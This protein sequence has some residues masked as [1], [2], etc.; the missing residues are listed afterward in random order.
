MAKW[1][2][3]RSLIGGIHNQARARGTEPDPELVATLRQR[4]RAERA[5]EYVT[6]LLTGQPA[7]SG[8]QLAHLAGILLSA[9]ENMRGTHIA[10][11]GGDGA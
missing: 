6:R 3:T 1:H 4:L 2:Q 7:L 9:P 5:E 10:A 11:A 8:D